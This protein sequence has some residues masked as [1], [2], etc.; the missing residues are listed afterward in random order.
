MNKIEEFKK[1]L[2]SND[3]EFKIKEEGDKLIIQ[4]SLIVYRLA[5]RMA[6]GK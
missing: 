2:I 6:N 5:M 4:E 1:I 3:I